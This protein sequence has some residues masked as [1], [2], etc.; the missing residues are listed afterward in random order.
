MTAAA[1]DESPDEGDTVDR[2]GAGQGSLAARIDRLFTTLRRPDGREFG[3]DEVAAALGGTGGSTISANYLY[4]LRRG[5]RDN[6]TKRHLEALAGFF[7]VP[8]AYFFDDDAAQRIDEELATLAALRDAKVVGVAMRAAGLS[9]ESLDAIRN[10]IE[11]ARRIE[12]L[13]TGSDSV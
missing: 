3:Y 2:F 4:M 6:P 5:Q 11:Q 7:R 10:M 8:V 12:G 9:P 13:S 1:G